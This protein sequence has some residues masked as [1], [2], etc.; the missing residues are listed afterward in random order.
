MFYVLIWSSTGSSDTVI[1]IQAA[2]EI[3]MR[4]IKHMFVANSLKLLKLF[5]SYPITRVSSYIAIE[6]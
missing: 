5:Y 2:K 6:L 4:L 3:L 1:A